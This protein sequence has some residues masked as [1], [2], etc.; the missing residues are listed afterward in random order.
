MTS[1][2]GS[3]C[4]RPPCKRLHPRHDRVVSVEREVFPGPFGLGG[5]AGALHHA[6]QRRLWNDIGTPQAYLKAHQDLLTG[7]A[8]G[9]PRATALTLWGR[10]G[11]LRR[12]LLRQRPQRARPRARCCRGSEHRRRAAVVAAGAR[13][14][15]SVL[16]RGLQG[17]R[18]RR[19]ELKGAC[20]PRA[21]SA[22]SPL[23]RRE[24]GERAGAAQRQAW[25]DDS[26]L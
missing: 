8:V 2:P 12:N 21:S 15:A 7:I 24:A 13:V 22:G 26:R 1:T 6:P 9:R 3:T 14:E 16:A 5:H 18:T 17:W 25:P 19:P 20:W 11:R 10:P 23:P 4:C